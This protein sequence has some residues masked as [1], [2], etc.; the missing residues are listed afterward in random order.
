[1]RD[2][3]SSERVS[4]ISFLFVLYIYLCIAYVHTP[5]ETENR[6]VTIDYSTVAVLPQMY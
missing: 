5:T 6:T 2:E 3:T 1:M 4:Y